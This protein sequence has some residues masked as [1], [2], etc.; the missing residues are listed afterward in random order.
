[1]EV[2]ILQEYEEGFVPA[3]TK[4]N[5][6][7]IVAYFDVIFGLCCVS[8]F[9]NIREMRNEDVIAKAFGDKVDKIV[10][11]FEGDLESEEQIIEHQ[12]RLEEIHEQIRSQ[13]RGSRKH[14]Q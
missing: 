13:Q 1:M 7:G 2:S 4:C 11:A 12:K 5:C 10:K 6:F 8:V 3:Y 9:N 14:I